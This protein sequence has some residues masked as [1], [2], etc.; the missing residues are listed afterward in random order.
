MALDDPRATPPPDDPTARDADAA[1]LIGD[2]RLPC[3]RLVSHAWEQARAAG[4]Q[5]DPHMDGCAFC[6]QAVEGLTALDSTTRTLC[7]ERPSARTVAD[8]VMHAVRAEVRL[9]RML[10]L[11]DPTRELRMAETAAAK[12]LRRAA[13]RV[14]GV[15]AASCRLTPAEGS[16]RVTIA[17]TLAVTLDRP[18][19]GRAAEVRRAVAHAAEHGL[20]LAVSTIDLRI[21]S[22]LEPLKPLR[23]LEPT[24]SGEPTPRDGSGR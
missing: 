18:L 21:V 16:T 10:P 13:D 12:V 24:A 14:P 19:P 1:W 3:G 6:R 15:R 9:G 22:V 11:D 23:P 2:E 4:D 7:A 20:G 8:R 5:P 17:M